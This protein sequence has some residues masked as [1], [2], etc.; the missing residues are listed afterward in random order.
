MPKPSIPR[1][2]CVNRFLTIFYNYR[3]TTAHG[4]TPRRCLQKPTIKKKS[5]RV[6]STGALAYY[7]AVSQKVRSPF[8]L[9]TSFRF[10]Y[11]ANLPVGVKKEVTFPEKSGKFRWPQRTRCQKR[12]VPS[13]RWSTL[14]KALPSIASNNEKRPCRIRTNDPS[15]TG[16]YFA[17]RHDTHVNLA[18]LFLLH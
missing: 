3:H 5:R 6:K 4:Q 11:T 2:F 15:S 12:I 16:A 18:W 9:P 13:E 10:H 1:I 17:C 14:W 7:A 8:L